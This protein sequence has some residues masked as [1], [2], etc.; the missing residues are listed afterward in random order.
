MPEP[1]SWFDADRVADDARERLRG[2]FRQRRPVGVVGQGERQ[3]EFYRRLTVVSAGVIVPQ[4]DEPAGVLETLEHGGVIVPGELAA[5][6][7]LPAAPPALLRLAARAEPSTRRMLKAKRDTDERPAVQR[8]R[9]RFIAA[10][11]AHAEV[12]RRLEEWTPRG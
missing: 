12:H 8:L 1:L 11:V 6:A 7:R 5:A 10:A 3:L 9:E 4:G 2:H